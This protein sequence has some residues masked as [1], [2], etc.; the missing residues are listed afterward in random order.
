[1]RSDYN[2]KW[3]DKWYYTSW[4]YWFIWL[5]RVRTRLKGYRPVLSQ[6]KIKFIGRRFQEFHF[7]HIVLNKLTFVITII[8]FIILVSLKW[9]FDPTKYIIIIGLICVLFIWI[10]GMFLDKVGLRREFMNA[11]FKDVELK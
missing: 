5:R 11:Q 9:D 6:R 2:L 10:L 4:F 8:N 3:Y 7:G 1:M